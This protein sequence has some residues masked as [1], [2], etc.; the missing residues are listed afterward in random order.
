[1]R[2]VKS[3]KL[4][5]RPPS[6]SAYAEHDSAQTDLAAVGGRQDNNSALQSGKDG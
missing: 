4:P 3:V 5:P 2:A 1:M 6:L